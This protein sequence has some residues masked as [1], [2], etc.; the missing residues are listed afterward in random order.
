L[1]SD[2][3]LPPL[4]PPPDA[5]TSDAKDAAAA[6]DGDSGTGGL[7]PC[8]ALKALDAN[9]NPTTTAAPPV[10][11]VT[12]PSSP[13]QLIG[14][15]APAM[16]LDPTTPTTIVYVDLTSCNGVAAVVAGTPL[17]ANSIATY[18]DPNSKTVASATTTAKEESC[19]LT[20]SV[21]ADV[22][23]SDVFAPT[24]GY[25][26]QGLPPG[27]K[28]FQG[29]VQSMT[30]AVPK[31][32]NQTVISAQA[33]YLT[34]GL[35]VLPPWTDPTHL[36]IHATTSGTQLMISAAIGVDVT[37]WQGTNAK[38][39]NGVFTSL[40]AQVAQTDL[41][42]SIGVLSA[43][44]SSK[45]DI[46][47]LAYQHTGQ[48]CAYKPD[49]QPLDKL[50]TRNGNYAIW[51][52]MHLFTL[53]D[54]TGLAANARARNL[55]AYLI[56]SQT[57]PLGVNLIGIE[58]NA[59]VVPPCAMN[60]TRSAEMG[61]MSPVVLGQAPR[62]GCAFD[63]AATGTTTCKACTTAADCTSGQECSYGYCEAN[64]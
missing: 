48:S 11:Y 57:P 17:A 53:V 18:W 19:L 55:I 14:G 5:S 8:N 35:A 30:F 58:A 63:H 25:A 47:M 31:G 34:F 62:C 3:S 49:V 4:P 20:T 26:L 24:C 10:I 43:A 41:D 28:E 59:H 64:Q 52:P 27:M 7:Q 29:P 61:A 12:G 22:G 23:A 50:N 37:R 42:K 9:G 16:F 33:A 38:S 15:L 51:G 32:S 46:Q 36:F 1:T 54:G 40:T 45:P 39:S 2:G 21:T 56:G 60:V 44:F 13:L 6:P